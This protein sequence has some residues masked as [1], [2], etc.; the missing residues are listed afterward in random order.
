MNPFPSCM[1]YN[2]VQ[3]VH[4]KATTGSAT[5]SVTVLI[6]FVSLYPWYLWST[7]QYQKV[8]HPPGLTVRLSIHKCRS[9]HLNHRQTCIFQIEQNRWNPT[10]K[11]QTSNRRKKTNRPIS[12]VV[13]LFW[14]SPKKKK[15]RLLYPTV[16][17]FEVLGVLSPAFGTV[18]CRRRSPP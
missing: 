15:T 5:S 16:C 1:Q 7:D 18:S 2:T 6:T 9:C 14:F 11:Q 4:Q 10:G 8:R 12:R 17:I 3:T 13:V